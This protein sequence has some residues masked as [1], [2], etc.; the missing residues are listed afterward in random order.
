MEGKVQEYSTNLYQNYRAT[1][2]VQGR[3]GFY[4]S[5]SMIVLII[6][7][8]ADVRSWTPI[9]ISVRN[10]Y[11]A[12]NQAQDSIQEVG[13]SLKHIK[14][15][16]ELM[17]GIEDLLVTSRSSQIIQGYESHIMSYMKFAIDWR[18]IAVFWIEKTERYLGE[19]LSIELHNLQEL[20]ETDLST[21]DIL[22]Y[23]KKILT[24]IDAWNSRLTRAADI[25]RTRERILTPKPI[26]MPVVR[27]SIEHIHLLILLPLVI[28]TLFSIWLRMLIRRE[29]LF[30]QYKSLLEKSL[31]EPNTKS[32]SSDML[33]FPLPFETSTKGIDKIDFYITSVIKIL[34]LI[35][36]LI[37]VLSLD[38]VLAVRAIVTPDITRNILPLVIAHSLSLLYLGNSLR[39]FLSRKAR[40]APPRQ[41]WADRV[42]KSL[43]DRGR[44]GII[45]MY[46]ITVVL[47]FIGWLSAICTFGFIFAS[48]KH[49]IAIKQGEIPLLPPSP[50]LYYLGAIALILA[51]VC[52][53]YGV[54]KFGK[55]LG[56]V[57][58]RGSILV[59]VM[60]AVAVVIISLYIL[61]LAFRS[62]YGIAG[63]VLPIL[64][65]ITF[66][67]LIM[68]YFLYFS[69][70]RN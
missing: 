10:A 66:I 4:L 16:E 68:V 69:H 61:Y 59:L 30:H 2:K 28:A 70:S 49:F 36:P 23:E 17:E 44:S 27:V 43:L 47:Q 13:I 12:V 19:S 63:L 31:A 18:D 29:I 8:I 67:I 62:T 54:R 50:A 15:Y 7:I 39:L 40:Q 46:F 56:R 48:V 32:M 26:E 38:A 33:I 25:L 14:E 64:L 51:I 55:W 9:L 58:R 6:V 1:A 65:G 11:Y 37:I 3:Y 60:V 41:T 20:D 35:S 21:E 57:S 5:I 34:F 53:Y 24:L 45:A 52:L 22:Q 42:S